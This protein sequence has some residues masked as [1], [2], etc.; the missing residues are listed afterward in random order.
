MV[1]TQSKYILLMVGR[2]VDKNHL[3]FFIAFLIGIFKELY[4][5][6]FK[7]HGVGRRRVY[8]LEELLGLHFWG[9][10]FGNESCRKK[11]NLFNDNN[12][13]LQ[14][15]ISGNPKKSKINEFK[16]EHKEL[17]HAFDNF[18]VEF[19]LI[20]GL[21]DANEF[22]VDGTFLDGYCN[23]FKALYP[24]EIRYIQEFLT[25]ND[26]H[27]YEL[28][29]SYFL[30]GEEMND[31]TKTLIN[32]IRNNTN[33][34]GLNLILQALENDSQYQM[35]MNK[36][37]HM[38]ENI[39]KDSV[40]VSIVDP[41]AHNMKDKDNNWGFHYNLQITTDT[42]NGIIVDHYVTKNPNDR[43]EIKK[44]VY[45]LI[46]KFNHEGFALGADNGYWNI[47]LLMEIIR[48]TCVDLAIPD[49]NTA[50]KTKQK[51]I[52]KS[53]SNKRYGQYIEEKKKNKK[54]RTFIDTIDFEYIDEE[55]AFECPVMKCHLK[56]QRIIKDK[57]GIE[58]REY[59]T[60]ECKNCPHLE[61]CTSQNK[62]KILIIN[63]PEIQIINKFYQSERGEKI[64]N[65][66]SSYAE[67]TFATNLENRNFRG[68]KVLGQQRVNLELTLIMI[69]H[70]ILKIIANVEL[71]VLKKVLRYIK[72][73][74]K[75][76]RASIDML[77]EL[78]GNFIEKN[79]KIVDVLI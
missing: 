65:K 63:E 49:K 66:R 64:K 30:K 12:E 23:D 11:E 35:I 14:I 25:K 44:I 79:G 45:R 39:T 28:L 43:N 37:T 15:L 24:D 16:N 21:V 61:K 62:R 77:Y 20:S 32:E 10:L 55:D 3:A 7:P 38:S 70:N 73:E 4:P 53:K 69:L 54:Q 74:K 72:S 51:I 19:C 52:K 48:N 1:S 29:Y 71:I 58:Y 36:L 50:Q 6:Y 42:K 60:N 76:R 27:D 78:Q 8:P 46:E 47:R 26:K 75:H 22:V 57:E 2:N 13:A 40:K 68:L 5:D 31:E 67:G 41:E 59:C 33:L 56:F 17:I 34:F 18:I 9:D